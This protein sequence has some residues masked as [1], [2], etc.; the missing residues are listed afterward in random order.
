MSGA[1]GAGKKAAIPLLFC[2]M[3]ESVRAYNAVGHRHL[4][5]IEQELSLAAGQAVRI[6]FTPY[7]LPVTAGITSTIHAMPVPDSDPQ[8]IGGIYASVYES[9]PF[10]RVLGEGVYPDTKNVT[11]TNFI[12][13]GW[14]HDARTGRLTL[15]SAEDNLGKG[16]AGQAV[17][18]ANLMCGF[19]E[20][21]GLLSF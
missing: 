17:Q 18:S 21:T 13:I 10:V 7:V 3:N 14:V 11:G 5:E 6:S 20:T 1:S 15:F 19:P 2:E 12:D 16:A 9:E 4:A 8:S